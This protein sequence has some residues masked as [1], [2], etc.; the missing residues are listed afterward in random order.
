VH[1]TTNTAFFGSKGFYSVAKSVKTCKSALGHPNRFKGCR[2]NHTMGSPPKSFTLLLEALSLK[3]LPRTGWVLRGAPRESVAE[4]THGTAVIALMLSRMEKLGAADE[5]A[6][7]RIALLHD[8]HEAR[9]GDLVP[10][11][12]KKVKP[13]EAKV[14]REM[15][16][17]TL[18]EP[19]ILLLSGAHAKKRVMLLA[20]DA[21]RLDML[22][23]AVENEKGGSARMQEFIDSALAQIKSKSGK[24][25]SRL[26]IAEKEK[27]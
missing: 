12:K 10:E 3:N 1:R 26:A 21:D 4:H 14:E 24:K 19:E 13:D 23:R 11:Q 5:A 27:K 25:L 6:L 20:H 22:F 7:V 17:G 8:L 9:I 15:L 18:F 2:A 16:S